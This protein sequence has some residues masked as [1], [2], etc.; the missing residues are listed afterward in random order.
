MKR[1]EFLIQS[2]LAAITAIAS[3]QLPSQSTP[4]YKQYKSYKSWKSSNIFLQ[5][6]NAPVFEEVEINNLKTSGKVPEELQ[7]MYLRNGPNPMFKPSSYN[8]PLEGDGMLHSINFNRGKVSYKNRWIQTRGL[9]YEMFEGQEITELKFKNYANTNI[10]GY[11]NKLLA[12]YEIGLPYAIDNNLETVGEWDFN[13]QLEQS[14][15][16]HPK[17]DPKTGE[18]HFYRY[19]F[20]NSPYLHYYIADKNGNIIRKTPINVSEPVMFHDMVITDNYAIFFHCPLVFNLQQAKEENQPF[21]WQPQAGTTV[22]LVDRH[23]NDKKPIYLQTD[24]FWVWHFMNGFEENGKVIIDFVH[25][26]KINME[27]HW[28]AILNN[29]SNLQR[30]TID[31][32]TQ[33]I[34]SE[35]LDDHYVDFPT[36][37]NDKIGQAY[38]FGYA[39]YIDTELLSK[40]KIPNYFP[41]LIQYDLA[42]KTH[43]IHQF[44]PGCYGGEAAFIPSSKGE[45]ELDGYV[46]TFVYNE[47][48]NTSDFVIID[49]RNFASE[50]IATVHLPVRV[51]GGFHGNWI[52]N[53]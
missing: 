50:P 35:S 38:S 9:T 33:Q 30:M 7:G 21:V 43:K 32:K 34:I 44:K 40:R 49:P 18:L 47:N 1:R 15:T 41:S 12:L 22:I 26:P 2:S 3:H 52:P 29:K 48:T 4:I 27:S 25:Y 28:Q 17:L 46:V 36:I 51:P 19:S 8:Y 10:I 31:L 39:P 53:M 37:N 11:G 5:G 42:K 14:M 24:A 45:S 20:F 13:G 16:A 6:I 23:N